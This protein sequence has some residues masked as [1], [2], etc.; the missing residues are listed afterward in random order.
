[1][2]VSRGHADVAELPAGYFVAEMSLLTG[3]PANADVTAVGP[4][5]VVRWST[6]ELRELRQRNPA[7]WT[8]IQSVIGHDLVEKIRRGEGR[9]V[10]RAEASEPEG[11]P[12]RAPRVA[13]S[14]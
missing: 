11:P 4:V 6:S 14:S 9:D 2:R 12:L 5:D 7:L 10:R 1:M 13:E 8:K 3:E